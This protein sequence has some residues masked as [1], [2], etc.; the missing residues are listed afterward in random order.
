ME[1]GDSSYIDSV[2]EL[3]NLPKDARSVFRKLADVCNKLPFYGKLSITPLATDTF[4]ER[5]PYYKTVKVVESL[6]YLSF[7]TLMNSTQIALS[8]ARFSQNLEQFN[9]NPSSD[10]LFACGIDVIY[11]TAHC[12]AAYSHLYLGGRLAENFRRKNIKSV[13]IL[14]AWGIND[15]QV[16]YEQIA[17]KLM[18]AIANNNQADIDTFFMILPKEEKQRVLESI[19]TIAPMLDH[20]Y[21]YEDVGNTIE[22]LGSN[23]DHKSRL[24]YIFDIVKHAHESRIKSPY[25]LKERIGLGITTFGGIAGFFAFG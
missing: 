7:L 24:R 22:K 21:S 16:N 11:G 12:A 17:D 20:S 18:V 2:G 4:R 13:P 3:G 15:D 6:G 1:T 19:K 8:A 25:S 14:K 5:N 23:I 9:N 10:K